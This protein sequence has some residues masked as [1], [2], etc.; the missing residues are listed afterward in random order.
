MNSAVLVAIISFLGTL[1][2]TAG[3]IIAS[4]KLTEYRLTQ[5]E[6]KVDAHAAST[7]KIPIFEEKLSN[8]NGR[9]SILEK[10]VV[11]HYESYENR[12]Q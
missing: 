11:P 12:I 1:I 3:G 2:G 5:L 9:I 6:K 10:S 7:S 4:G 8:L